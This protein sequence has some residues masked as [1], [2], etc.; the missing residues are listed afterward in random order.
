MA[1]K[2]SGKKAT[3]KKATKKTGG[4]KKAIRKKKATKKKK[5]KKKKVKVGSMR[6]VFSGTADRTKGGLK[7]E[8]LC[9]NKRGKVVSKKANKSAAK[10]FKNSALSKWIAATQ[11]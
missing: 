1:A 6:R 3:K 5:I 8:D 4:K 7:K 9:R 2:K 10:N 11:S